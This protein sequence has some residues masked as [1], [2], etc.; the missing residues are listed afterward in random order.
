[1]IMKIF[2]HI[3]IYLISIIITS[4]SNDISPGDNKIVQNIEVDKIVIPKGEKNFYVIYGHTAATGP[5]KFIITDSNNDEI[6][7]GSDWPAHGI[8]KGWG[9]EAKFSTSKPKSKGEISCNILVPKF[10]LKAKS[11]VKGYL[12]VPGVVPRIVDHKNNIFQE[13]SVEITSKEF[14]ISI[15]PTITGKP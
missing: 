15:R 14:D 2:K 9:K 6:K 10:L 3:L 12:L 7:R 13:S 11:K 8:D 4:C 1:M 5:G